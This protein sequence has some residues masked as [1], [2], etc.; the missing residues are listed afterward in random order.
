MRHTQILAGSV[1]LRE[2]GRIS[3]SPELALRSGH[4]HTPSSPLVLMTFDQLCE[5]RGDKKTDALQQ[6]ISGQ[7]FS[8]VFIQQNHPLLTLQN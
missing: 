6:D 3:M 7:I 4:S 2:G 8:L 5:T 1:E